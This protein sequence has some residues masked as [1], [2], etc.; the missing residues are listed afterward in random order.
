MIYNVVSGA[1]FRK[2]SCDFIL[3]SF[4]GDLAK[5]ISFQFHSKLRERIKLS[6]NLQL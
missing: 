3:S 5:F 1:N 2:A 6:V 4:Y